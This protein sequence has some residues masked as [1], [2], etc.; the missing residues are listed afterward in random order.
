MSGLNTKGLAYAL[1]AL[2]VV[3]LWACEPPRVQLPV[4]ETPREM[5]PE[6]GDDDASPCEDAAACTDPE[7]PLCSP[8]G[9]CVQCIVDGD[10]VSGECEHG[11]CEDGEDG[12]EDE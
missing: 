6:P 9:D 1:L 8:A 2:A 3:Q 11:E 4:R 10:C 12:E 5:E 7:R